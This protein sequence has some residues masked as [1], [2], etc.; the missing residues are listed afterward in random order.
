MSDVDGG[1]VVLAQVWWVL[2][3]G[4]S[5]SRGSSSPGSQGSCMRGSTAPIAIARLSSVPAALYLA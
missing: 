1:N 3:D 4:R 5:Y 2:S